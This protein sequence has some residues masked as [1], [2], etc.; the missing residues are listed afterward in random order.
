MAIKDGY[1]VG[2]VSL[3]AWVQHFSTIKR[4]VLYVYTSSVKILFI[5]Q[6]VLILRSK[7]II[8]ISTL[9]LKLAVVEPTRFDNCTVALY[10]YV[11]REVLL[12]P[13]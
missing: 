9:A 12:F 4:K 2:S 1:A 7:V 10:Y 11:V 5:H 6:S 8:M 3:S 13:V